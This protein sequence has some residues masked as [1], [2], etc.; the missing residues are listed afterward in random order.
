[1]ATAFL[2]VCVCV[3]RRLKSFTLDFVDS[4]FSIT[5]RTERLCG[6]RQVIP[7]SAITCAF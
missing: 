3:R 1:M 5:Q 2:F 6:W 4:D 7:I